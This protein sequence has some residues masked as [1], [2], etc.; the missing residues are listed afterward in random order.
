MKRTGAK[1]ETWINKGDADSLCKWM[2][3]RKAHRKARWTR[4][5]NRM[6]DRHEKKEWFIPWEEWTPLPFHTESY[7]TRRI[8]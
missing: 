7:A 2:D 5:L 4:K 1:L 6:L 3:S 8:S